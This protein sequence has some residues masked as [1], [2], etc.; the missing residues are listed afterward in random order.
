MAAPLQ[1]R[2][3]K[4]KSLLPA[5]QKP[6]RPKEGNP[7]FYPGAAAPARRGSITRNHSGGTA[8]SRMQPA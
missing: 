5:T 4:D 2:G 3:C 1:Q 8:A 7:A 6:A